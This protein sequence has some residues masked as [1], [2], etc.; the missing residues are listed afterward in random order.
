MDYLSDM[1]SIVR[2]RALWSG[3]PVVG[4]GVSVFHFAAGSSSGPATVYGFFDT[5]KGTIPNGVTIVVPGVGDTIDEN[6]GEID[7]TWTGSGGGTINSTGGSG[8]W[9]AGVGARVVWITS[10]ITRGRRVRGSTFVVPMTAAAYESNGTLTSAVVSG[11]NTASTYM[12]ADSTFGVYTRPQAGLSNGA[13]HLQ[14][15]SF[16]PDA[17]TWLRSRRT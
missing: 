5:L 15:A 17:V 1:A 8:A 16:I 4:G 10:G 2:L 14:V 7:G 3:T 11:L 13:F 6:T 12:D 9:A